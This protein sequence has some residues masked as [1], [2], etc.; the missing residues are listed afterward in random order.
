[1][2]ERP[3]FTEKC[4]SASMLS[5]QFEN[6]IHNAL[7]SIMHTVPKISDDSVSSKDASPVRL[8][9]DL[10]TEQDEFGPH[11]T[12]AVAIADLIE[13]EDGGKAIALEGGWGS[14]KSSVVRMLRNRLKINGEDAIRV[15]V[16]DAWSHEGD[17]L[18]RAFLEELT[19]FCL[20]RFDVEAQERWNEEKEKRITG[21]TRISDQVTTPILKSKW[22]IL[23]LAGGALYPVALVALSGLLRLDTSNYWIL[24]A[25]IFLAIVAL[26]P[27][28][29]LLWVF[30]ICKL[31]F[32]KKSC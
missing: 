12:L 11:Q 22:P 6:L 1:M 31:H 29:F 13:T 9:T 21:R 7:L 26:G 17:P 3:F 5:F 2:A 24:G 28:A 32:L 4:P 18:R 23:F 14:G 8:L 16:F 20:D 15:H 25:I 10:P 27:A 19:S 30:R